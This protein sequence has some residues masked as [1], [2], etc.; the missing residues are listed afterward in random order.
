M[1]ALGLS[2]AAPT[3]EISSELLR[4][5]PLPEGVEDAQL[6]RSQLATA[7]KVTEPTIT[8]WM[9]HDMPMLERGTNGKQ[10]KFLLSHCYA[11]VRDR[12]ATEAKSALQ[13]QASV[14][15]MRLALFPDGEEDENNGLSPK[16]RR[17][18]YA[19][20]REYQITA[21][22]RG[23]L[24]PRADVVDLLE[25]VFVVMRDGAT[26]LPDRLER[27]MGLSAKQVERAIELTD[28]VLEDI[29]HKIE[30]KLAPKR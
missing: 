14:E 3:K 22:S 29:K 23:E 5:Y 16:D 4:Q 18:V 1:S 10:Y 24:I 27:D 6:N 26:S 17:E 28:A 25:T 15:Q 21:T 12:E 20:D 19:A 11:W 2:H 30:L 7:L 8:A 13:A 9:R